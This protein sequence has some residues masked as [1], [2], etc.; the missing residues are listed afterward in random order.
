MK[1]LAVILIILTFAFCKSQQQPKIERFIIDNPD[2]EKMLDSIHDFYSKQVNQIQNEAINENNN[3]RAK[4]KAQLKSWEKSERTYQKQIK[5]LRSDLNKA[6][7]KIEKLSKR[8]KKIY[9][10][11][12]NVN[13]IDCSGLND[14]ITAL[15]I[16]IDQNNENI[17][18]NKPDN[19]VDN[20]VNVN[21]LKWW[22]KIWNDI[23]GYL[24]LA[25]IVICLILLLRYFILRKAPKR[26]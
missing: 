1:K 21:K 24:A 12:S 15:N 19:S 7:K 14:S 20:S 16:I 26:V 25:F 22:E 5:G 4:H 9:I 8:P 17:N 2:C 13:N 18:K 3:L 23:S 6:E 10:T 11:K